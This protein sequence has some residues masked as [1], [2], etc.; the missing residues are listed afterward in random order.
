MA[1][2]V[3]S[4]APELP[5]R[6]SMCPR[7][8]CTKRRFCGGALPQRSGSLAPSSG[9]K[10]PFCSLGDIGKAPNSPIEGTDAP[11]RFRWHRRLRRRPQG[12]AG[13]EAA[14]G[15]VPSTIKPLGAKN[16]TAKLDLA[17]LLCICRLSL[18]L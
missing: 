18:S 2:A 11:G 17:L 7:A 5:K 10:P 13:G 14:C 8:S 1:G 12:S 15:Y 16:R 9:A 3:R 4:T 6:D